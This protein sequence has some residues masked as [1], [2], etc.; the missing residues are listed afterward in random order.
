MYVNVD[1]PLIKLISWLRTSGGRSGG[2]GEQAMA[3][4]H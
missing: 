2:W 4:T 1:P 3:N